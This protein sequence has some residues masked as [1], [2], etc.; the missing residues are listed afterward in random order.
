MPR[1]SIVSPLGEAAWA[2]ILGEAAEGYEEGDP[3][4]W[5]INLLLDPSQP[6]TIAFIEQLEAAFDEFHGKAK[7]A[8]NGWPYKDQVDKDERGRPT[9]TGKIQVTFKRKEFTSKGNQKSAP[10]VVDAKKKPWPVDMLIGNGSKVK[11]A[12]SPWPWGTPT[13]KGMSLELES[14]QVIDLVAYDKPAA[15]DAFQ[16]EDGYEVATPESATPFQAEP[17]CPMPEPSGFA[18]QLKARAAQVA[19][20]ASELTEDVPF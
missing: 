20:E 1:Q 3:R 18:A 11:V 13:G 14:V 16:E 17:A 15:V 7:V 6:E 4:A 8:N 12:F 2:K 9:P 5:S 10:I 19:A